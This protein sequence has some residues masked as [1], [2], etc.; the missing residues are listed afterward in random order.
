ME[1]NIMKSKFWAIAL[2]LCSLCNYAC[3]S[4]NE[5]VEEQEFDN[6]LVK[7]NLDTDLSTTVSE[8]SDFYARFTID[9]IKSSSKGEI[10]NSENVIVSPFSAGVLLGMLSNGF[11]EKTTDKIIDYLGVSD[12]SSVNRLSK[13]L[14]EKLPSA[15]RKSEVCI[16]NSFWYDTNR[17][18]NPNFASLLKDKYLA[19]LNPL[20]F[21]QSTATTNINS[22]IASAT[23]NQSLNYFKQLDPD[24]MAILLSTLYFNGEWTPEWIDFNIENTQ[25]GKFHGSKGDKTVDMMYCEQGFTFYVESDNYTACSLMFGNTAFRLILILPNENSSVTDVISQLTPADIIQI[26]HSIDFPTH[27]STSIK[28]PR[29]SVKGGIDFKELATVANI[30]DLKGALTMFTPETAGSVKMNQNASFSI[31]EAGAKAVVVT[32]GEIV[33]SGGGPNVDLVFDRPFYFLLEHFETGVCLL[34]GLVADIGD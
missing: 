33:C 34:S 18:V 21:N 2:I 25:K 32:D 4:D 26:Q 19:S 9:A 15:D 14:I 7:L 5:P 29:F 11:E 22:W 20:D 27:K 28:L 10:K 8:L 23:K 13:I 12:I 30:P 1:K 31:D 6:T 24:I 16:N 3:S 17:Q